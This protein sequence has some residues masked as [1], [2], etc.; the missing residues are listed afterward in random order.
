MP[1]QWRRSA[2]PPISLGNDELNIRTAAGL[3]AA[4]E[5]N[6]S[7]PVIQAIVYNSKES[8]ILDDINNH[9]KQKYDIDFI[10]DVASSY[11][12]NVLINSELE[13]EAKLIHT[14]YAPAGSLFD[15]EYNYRSS[16]ASAIHAEAVAWKLMDIPK[17]MLNTEL[18]KRM[19]YWLRLAYRVCDPEAQV[20]C[21]LTGEVRGAL[22]LWAEDMRNFA[23]DLITIGEDG[24]GGDSF[25]GGYE[26][27]NHLANLATGI[28]IVV[29]FRH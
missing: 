4:C 9:K 21:T 12:E 18:L 29:I 24:V 11:T 5:R 15:Y 16:C 10:G 25:V 3:R 19:E 8:R 22:E 27:R 7:H 2:I 1:G 20:N 28:P 17:G 26:E 14:E 6:G 23:K 13:D